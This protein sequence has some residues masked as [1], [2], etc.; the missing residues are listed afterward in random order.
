MP[1]TAALPT[2]DWSK[3]NGC[4]R[5]A[6]LCP[7]DAVSVLDGRAHLV[8]PEACTFCPTCETYCPTE[9]IGRPFSVRFRARTGEPKH[10]WTAED[11]WYTRPERTGLGHPTIDSQL[12][13]AEDR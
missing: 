11:G 13:A 12:H 3:C 8:R 1:E 7:T 4:G 10:Q 9:A 5:C 6:E 2:I